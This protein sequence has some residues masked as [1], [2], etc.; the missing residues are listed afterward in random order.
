MGCLHTDLCDAL[1]VH[2]EALELPVARGDGL[3]EAVGDGVGPDALDHV[4]DLRAVGL[5]QALVGLLPVVRA[6]WPQTSGPLITRPSTS[7]LESGW[8][9][10]RALT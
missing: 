10:R 8:S 4:E 7:L 3:D 5:A 1:S 2:A 9:D 6:S